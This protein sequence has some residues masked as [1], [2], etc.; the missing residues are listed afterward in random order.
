MYAMP[1]GLGRAWGGE[2]DMKEIELTQG[3]VALVDDSDFDFLNQ[4]NWWL[5]ADRYNFYATRETTRRS[6]FPRRTILM[7]RLIMTCPTNMEVDHIDGNGLNN[8]RSNLR[9]CTHHQNSANRRK[10][11]SSSSRFKGVS[12]KEKDK[13]WESRIGVGNKVVYLGQFKIEE[14][15]ALAYD[16]IAKE[17]RGEYAC[18]NFPTN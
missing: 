6:P 13:R 10:K 16:R 18:L 8:T 7:H 4:W 2:R 14:E 9:V 12:W 1:E 5:K 15:A 3:K 17:W 11:V